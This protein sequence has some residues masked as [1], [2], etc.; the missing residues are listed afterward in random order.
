MKN[1]TFKHSEEFITELQ[2]IQGLTYFLK[3]ANACVLKTELK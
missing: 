1:M 2:L 3:G